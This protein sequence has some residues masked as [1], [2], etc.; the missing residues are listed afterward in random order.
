MSGR[1]VHPFL[2]AC[3][4]PVCLVFGAALLPV[5]LP[6]PDAAAQENRRAAA[7]GI[8]V[9]Q[10]RKPMPGVEVRLESE[11]PVRGATPEARITGS[12]G[13]AELWWLT[14]G[15]WRVDLLID[16]K[17]AYF[18]TVRIDAGR[19]AEEMGSPA[20]DVDAPDLRWKFFRPE[21]SPPEPPEPPAPPPRAAEVEPPAPDIVEPVEEE[22]A[23]EPAVEEPAAAAPEAEEPAVPQPPAPQPVV[24]EPEVSPPPMR[25]TQAPPPTDD[26]VDEEP[27]QLRPAPEPEPEIE[28]APPPP[29]AP[30]QNPPPTDD[31]VDEEPPPPPAPVQVREVESREPPMPRGDEPEVQLPES[32]PPPPVQ[33]P[34][35]TAPQQQSPQPP[36]QPPPRD[37]VA[38]PEPT[39]TPPSQAP[40][41][42]DPVEAA[43]VEA[44]PAAA[45]RFATRSGAEGD[46]A[47]CKSNETAVT[48]E[49]TVQPGDPG[50]GAGCGPGMA[51][52]ALR[53]ARSLASRGAGLGPGMPL[54]G[55]DLAR[56]TSGDAACQLMGV[57]LPPGVRY[58][59]YTYEVE[60]GGG[61]GG[62]CYVP[63]ACPVAGAVWPA[64]PVIEEL[65]GGARMVYGVFRNASA[66]PLRAKMT[67]FYTTP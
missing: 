64:R 29:M 6:A 52:A 38:L 62:P 32:A 28:P 42:P 46:C 36:P 44:A 20:R 51:E 58:R 60:A 31:P 33:R 8:E 14:P 40:P 26:P 53:A 45:P 61:A 66:V 63:R 10:G 24:E 18:L 59:G 39:P 16:G 3:L 21:G 25:P 49:R 4:I 5:L 50:G 12:D 65:E 17:V 37:P 13:R 2:C 57:V 35:V 1:R 11:G 56:F 23:A 19:R 15:I 22:V 34:R 67:V 27:P 7:F 54:D 30:T 41:M 43:P 9:R 48:L 47:E 55:G